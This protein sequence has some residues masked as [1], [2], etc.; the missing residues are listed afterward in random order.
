MQYWLQWGIGANDIQ[1]NLS[2]LSGGEIIK[3]L[4]IQKCFL[5]KI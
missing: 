2:D 4:F 5:G 3:L 1:K